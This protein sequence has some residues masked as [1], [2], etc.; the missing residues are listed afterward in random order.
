M[1]VIERLRIWY[2]GRYVPPPPIDHESIVIFGNG[3]YEQPPLAK[4]LGV[5]GRF[6]IA[7]WQW[8][9]GTVLAVIAIV[10]AL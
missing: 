2:R 7:H 10:V 4:M 1:A 9:I 3:H 8:V 6:Y 5:L